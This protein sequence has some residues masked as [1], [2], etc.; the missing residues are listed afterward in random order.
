MYRVR[1]VSNVSLRYLG[2]G[3]GVQVKRKWTDKGKIVCFSV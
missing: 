3:V 1:D 2:V